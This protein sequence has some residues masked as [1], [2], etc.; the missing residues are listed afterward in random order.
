MYLCYNRRDLIAAK[1]LCHFTGIP[2]LSSE[3]NDNRN[4]NIRFGLAVSACLYTKVQSIDFI[5]DDVLK[6]HEQNVIRLLDGKSY[7][8]LIPV[9]ASFVDAIKQN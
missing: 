6:E 4:L 5:T 8:P 2:V 3:P 7:Y 1:A 9:L